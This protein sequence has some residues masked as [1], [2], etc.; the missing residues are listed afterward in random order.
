M[1]DSANTKK[2]VQRR[3]AKDCTALKRRNGAMTTNTV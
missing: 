1:P 2:A 3:F